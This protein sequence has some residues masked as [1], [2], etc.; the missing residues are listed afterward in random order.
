MQVQLQRFGQATQPLRSTQISG[1]QNNDNRDNGQF[2]EGEWL[3]MPGKGG[4][5]SVPV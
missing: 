2:L 5:L 1:S 4:R 3:I